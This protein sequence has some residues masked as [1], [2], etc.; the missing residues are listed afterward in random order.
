MPKSWGPDVDND[1][2]AD[3]YKASVDAVAANDAEW[4][5]TA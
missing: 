3:S 2:L 4:R 1:Y 5:V